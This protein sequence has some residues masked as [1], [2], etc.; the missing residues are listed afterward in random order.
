MIQKEESN[1]TVNRIVFV[2]GHLDLTKEEFEE[3]YVPRLR[4]AVDNGARF[5]V[6]DAAGADSMTQQWLVEN[7]SRGGKCH[8]FHML[9]KP[10]YCAAIF[11]SFGGYTSDEERDS[12]MTKSSTED[13]AW[14]RRGR[15][16][17]GTAKNLKRRIQQREASR[18]AEIESWEPCELTS[19]EV[20]PVFS[21]RRIKSEQPRS[22]LVPSAKPAPRFPREL[23][24]R[25]DAAWREWQACQ[26]EIE[27]LTREQG[28]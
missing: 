21:I 3:H 19:C 5:V 24:E 4:K 2:S 14:V 17:S 9:E 7:D 1:E 13:I 26:N 28:V 15:E 18:K 10:R 25:S 22:S 8:V 27:K 20:Y 6:G 12:V 23:L 16:K 11:S